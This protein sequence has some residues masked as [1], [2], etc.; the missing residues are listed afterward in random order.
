[1]PSFKRPAA[2]EVQRARQLPRAAQVARDSAALA[3]APRP[4]RSRSRRCGR[5]STAS[6]ASTTCMNSVMT[7]GLHHRWR[8]R[9]ADLARGGPGRSRARRRP[10]TGDLALELARRV[11]PAARWSAPT[12]P[13]GCSSCARGARRAGACRLR[14]GQRARAALRGRRFDAATV[15]FGARNFAD[16]A[17]RAGRDGA[18]RAPGRP[19]RGARD[20]DPARAR[21]CRRSTASGSTASCRARRASRATATPTATCRARSSRFPGPTSWRRAMAVRRASRDV[22]YMLTAGGIIAHPRR[23]RSA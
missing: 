12:S 14:V 22:R 11:G 21:R 23:G 20:H 18:R 19:G 3:A 16:L 1:M 10:G 7:A 6:R 8:A 9:A 2:E 4:A 13:S 5:C 15:G 17:A